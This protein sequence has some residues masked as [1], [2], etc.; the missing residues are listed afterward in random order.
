MSELRRHDLIIISSLSF[1]SLVMGSNPILRLCLTSDSHAQC[2]THDTTRLTICVCFTHVKNLICSDYACCKVNKC[3][4]QRQCS[5]TP[6]RVLLF[7]LFES[8][9]RL[10][11]C[12]LFESHVRLS[13][14]VLWFESNLRPTTCRITHVVKSNNAVN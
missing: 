5:V 3:S 14:F 6:V 10:S 2:H 13:A 7:L 1:I 12:L 8:P 9:M 4:Q 11:A